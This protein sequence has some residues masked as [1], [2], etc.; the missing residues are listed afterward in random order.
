[1]ASTGSAKAAAAQATAARPSEALVSAHERAS[2]RKI[3]GLV[4]GP[5]VGL[6][7]W[8][9]PLSGDPKINHAL[10]IIGFMLVY[11]ILEPIDQGVTALF[12]SYL[13]WATRVVTF[14]AAFSGF[15][16]STP[17]FMLGGLL[18]GR[19]ADRSGLTRRLG[20]GVMKVIGT[21]YPRLLLSVIIIVFLLVFLVPNGLAQVAIL[22]PMLIGIIEAFGVDKKSNIGRGLF[23]IM[24]YTCGLFNKM[25]LAGGATVLTTGILH[26]FT[27]VQIAWSKYF[28]A[29]LPGDLVTIFACWLTILWLY[30]PEVRELPGG[31][32]YVQ[33]KL[34]ACGT[35]SGAEKKALFW[36]A[37]ALGLWS[38]DF[39]HHLNP[40]LVC[41]GVGL[42]LTLPVVGVLSTEDIRGINFLPIIYIAS[43]ISMGEVLIRTKAIQVLTN[44]T[45]GFMTPLL[46]GAVLTSAVLYWTGFVYHFVLASE[47]SMISTALPVLIQFSQTHGLNPTAI[48][49][50]WNFASGGK[51]FVY[52]SAVLMLGYAYGYFEAK[53]MLK[54][55][56]VLT[57]VEACV[58]LVLVSVY[59]P[60]IGLSLT[61][62][63]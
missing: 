40:A 21:S 29:Y 59:W 54:V 9:A 4:L 31:R 1:M 60:L 63:R 2:V 32:Q 48:A 52:Q 6:L 49:M 15:S 14:D 33:E 19:A 18:V 45:L 13:F 61:A 28:I 57:L 51:L 10:A 55:G 30:P 62:A 47:L 22:A 35:W 50:L 39:L 17:W 23:I 56:A 38:T 46:R 12:G 5:I 26:R 7:L 24:S 20:Y 37:L 11:W 36:A 27:G 53:D 58:L 34:A 16:D 3:V 41:I 43:V 8:Y 25:V 42:I 44:A